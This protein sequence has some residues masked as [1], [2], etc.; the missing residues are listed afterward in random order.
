MGSNLKRKEIASLCMC[1][2]CINKE[3]NIHLE[4]EDCMY[5]MFP[6]KCSSCGVTK[7]IVVNVRLTSKHKLKE[8]KK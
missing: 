3:Y 6:Q 2:R 4:T 5:S 1:R 8:H 7:D